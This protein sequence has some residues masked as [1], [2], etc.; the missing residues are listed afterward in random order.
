MIELSKLGERFE[1]SAGWIQ[2]LADFPVG[3]VQLIHSVAGSS[4]SHHRHAEDGHWLYCLSG[5]FDYVERRVGDDG[6]PEQRRIKAGECVFTGP[7]IDHSTYFPVDTVLISMSL[8]P[9][10][11]EAHE[12]D[13]I[14]VAPLPLT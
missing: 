14:R 5:Y 8:R 6:P 12:S 2:N 1:N 7:L 9:R 11:H 3:G 10:T 13:L 4:R